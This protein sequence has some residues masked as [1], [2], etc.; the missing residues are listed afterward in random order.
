MKR[1]SL[2]EAETFALSGH[3][4]SVEVDELELSERHEDLLDI[5]GGQLEVEVSNV[6][7]VVRNL[8]V[9]VSISIQT[10]TTLSWDLLA[11]AHERRQRAR[12]DVRKP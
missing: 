4:V 10:R 8:G 11:A 5:L 9:R 12:P 2:D 1:D 6:Q 3:R 7:P